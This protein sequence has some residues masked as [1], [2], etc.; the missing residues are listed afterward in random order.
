MESYLKIGSAIIYEVEIMGI[1]DQFNKLVGKTRYVVSRIF[2]QLSG[3]EVTPVLGVLNQASRQM[4]EADGDLTITGECLVEICQSL[5]QYEHAW[6]AAGNEG[7]MMW[8]EGDAGGYVN[9][10]FT[11]S[12][13]RYL[14]DPDPSQSKTAE[15]L[16]LPPTPNLVVMI[17]VAFTG[18][19]DTVEANLAEISAMK[20][21]L[22][23]LI[24]LHYQNRLEAIQVHF[25]PAK[26]GDQ[27]SDD[28]IL[29]NFPELLP[30]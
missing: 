19:D 13:Q 18:S 29:Q 4:I 2:L 11:D 5:L 21:A 14:S 24:N 9:E 1:G 30:L 12:A 26:L 7:D 22:K 17:T 28:Q 15:E 27:L 23:S 10:L 6:R 16:T 3:T 8:D 25:S 20:V